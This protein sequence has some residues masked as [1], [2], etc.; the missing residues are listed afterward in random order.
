METLTIDY[1]AFRW[2]SRDPI[3]EVGGIN[4]HGYVNNDPANLIDPNG[5]FA[6]GAVVGGLVGAVTGAIGAAGPGSDWEDI[7]SGALIGGLVGFGVGLLDPSE[8]I[9]TVLGLAAVGAGAGAL[10]DLAGQGLGMLTHP[11]RHLNGG[12]VAGAAIGGG[13]TGGVGSAM[14]GALMAAGA[15]DAISSVIPGIVTAPPSVLFPAL[16]KYWWGNNE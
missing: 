12:E 9:G 7:A 16:G 15:G 11:C 14:G 6:I 3:G 10:G 2:I 5:K 4:L 8:G 1:D 13:L